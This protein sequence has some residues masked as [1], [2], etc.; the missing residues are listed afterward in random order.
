MRWSTTQT[1]VIAVRD[2]VAVELLKVRRSRV[3]WTAALVA[4]V[5]IPLLGAAFVRVAGTA[6]SGPLAVKLEALVIG[7]GWE[8][9]TGVLGQLVSVA[10]LLAAGI[11]VIWSFGREF[12]DGTVGALFAL[13]VSRFTIA[14]AKVVATGLWS[15]GAAAGLAVAALATGL[16]FGLGVPDATDLGHLGGILVLAL[17]TALLAGPLAIAASIGRGYLPGIGL[18]LLVVAAAQISVLF[19]VGGWFP[20]AAPGLWAVSWQQPDLAVSAGQLALVPITAIVGVIA[21]AWWWGRFELT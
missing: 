5:L 11:V 8:A 10:Y 3:T 17:L 2:V 1:R 16:A 9:Y 6:G 14:V 7:T 13:P 12:T 18:L 20:Y 4:V 15:A 19:G 21:T